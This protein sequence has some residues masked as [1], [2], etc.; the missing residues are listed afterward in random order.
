MKPED[1]EKQSFAIIEKELSPRTFPPG[2]GDIVKR[3]IHTTADFSFADS[4]CFSDGAVEAGVA[5]MQAGCTIVTDTQMAKA[6]L[7][8]A[9]LARLSCRAVC[10]M[11]DPAVAAEAKRRQCTRAAVSME[12]AR[13]LSG[14]VLYALGNAPTALL[15]LCE[16]I[17]AGLSPALVVGVPVGFVNAAESKERLTALPVPYIVARGR[18]GGSTV[19]AA[20]CNALL[21]LAGGRG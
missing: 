21:Y 6:G 13:T 5:A 8:A 15:T 20:I 18:K 16:E 17:E 14:P 3:V 7:N 11:P 10:N 19:A 12:K 1:I 2:I 9:A 4:L